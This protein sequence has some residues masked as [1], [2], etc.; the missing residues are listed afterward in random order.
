[1]EGRAQCKH[2]YKKIKNTKRLRQDVRQG[3]DKADQGHLKIRG[4]AVE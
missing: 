1:M 4:S 3:I 2:F